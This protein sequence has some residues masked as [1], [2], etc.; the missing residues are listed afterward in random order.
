[1]LAVDMTVLYS[2]HYPKYDPVSAAYTF[3]TFILQ[4]IVFLL[5]AMHN[6]CTI[7][8]E[9][10]LQIW[11]YETASCVTETSSVC[12]VFLISSRIA[13]DRNFYDMDDTFLC[14]LHAYIVI[15]IPPPKKKTY[16]FSNLFSRFKVTVV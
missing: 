5:L 14:H 16:T 9:R 1:M 10:A 13:S 7:Y 12:V 8:K 11:K 2:G 3:F 6:F 15:N 4:Q